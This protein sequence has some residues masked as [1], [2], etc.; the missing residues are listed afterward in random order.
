VRESFTRFRRRALAA[1]VLGLAA[2]GVGAMLD[3]EQALRSWLVAFLF[4]LGL[5]LGSLAIVLLHH[6]TGGSWG[7]AIRRLLEAGMRTLPLMLLAFVPV[8]L[9]ATRLYPWA[10]AGAAE[11]DA[12]LAHKAPYLNVPF[13]L[14]RAALY[15]AVWLGLIAAMTGLTRSQDRS[16]HPNWERRMR[17]LSG[18][19]LAAYGLTMTFAAIDWAM[20]L[21]PHWFSTIYGVLFLV[22]QGLSTLALA[23][24]GAAWLSRREPFS[25]W[26]A[27]GHFHDL[28]NLTFAFVMLWGYVSFSQYLI[29]WS[30][31]LAEETPWY[32]SRTAHGWQVVAIALLALHFVVPFAVLLS[33]KTKR[34]ARLLAVVAA[35]LLAARVIDLFW[36]VTPAFHPAGLSVHWLDLAALL[37]LGG[38]WGFWYV[39]QLKGRP[40]LS[41]HDAHLESALEAPAAAAPEV[42]T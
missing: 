6:A 4:Y 13:F 26:L 5:S 33:R 7:F 8:A 37:G 25:R 14:G 17:F 22:G 35:G 31:N 38:A 39:G 41:L 28:G 12:L 11:H 10:G 3:P 30:G 34:N 29:I 9:G 19:G 16:G 21:E 15:F 1:A 40:L 27:R 20:S 32:L 23:I 24:L 2:V 42:A 36:L 18:P